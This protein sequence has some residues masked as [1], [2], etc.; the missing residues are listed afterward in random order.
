ML[1]LRKSV[2]NFRTNVA[3][4]LT[5]PFRIV[6]LRVRVPVKPMSPLC[7]AS[8]L[9]GD[10]SKCLFYIGCSGADCYS[11]LLNATR[12]GAEVIQHRSA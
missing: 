4:R 2:F 11:V 6:V 5:Q 12:F 3:S 1:D 7:F 8:L 9:L 10:P